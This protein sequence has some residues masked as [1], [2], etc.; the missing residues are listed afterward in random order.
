MSPLNTHSLKQ[1]QTPIHVAFF[2]VLLGVCAALH[3]WKLPPALPALQQELAISLVESGFLLS[4][5]QIA[6]MSLA[7]LIG[8]FAERIGLKRCILIGLAILALSSYGTVLIQNKSMM[9]LSR[10]VEGVGFLMVVLP[11]P[12]LMKRLVPEENISRMMGFWGTYMPA[13]AVTILLLG[14]W[15]ISMSSWRSLWLILGVITTV[16]WLLAVVI[17]PKDLKAVDQES[18]SMKSMMVVTLSSVRVWFVALIFGVYAAQWTAVIGFLPTIYAEAAV[19]STLAGLLTALVAGSNIIGSLSAGRLL[20]KGVTA[21]TLLFVSF[22]VMSVAAV[23][24]FGLQL[25]VVVQFIAILLFSVVGGLIP[26]TCFLLAVQLAP[27]PQTT[28]STIGWVQQ[29]SSMG[30]FIGAPAVA[31]VVSVLG[32]WQW[33]WVA[34]MAFAVVG[35]FMAFLLGK[36][37]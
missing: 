14:S 33:A 24:A 16:V 31:W 22:V 15:L 20:H 11:V 6:G 27:T 34:T 3:I 12:A 28:S 30:Q 21:T 19:A 35:L 29:G 9:I 13:A 23:V 5:V 10:T 36:K 8:L 17:I 7:L 32:G 2:L 26:A 18:S 1:S 4:S 25:G 37:V